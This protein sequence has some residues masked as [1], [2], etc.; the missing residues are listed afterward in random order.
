M[1]VTLLPSPGWNSGRGS[2]ADQTAPGNGPPSEF[3]EPIVKK[4]SYAK[5]GSSSSRATSSPEG[6]QDAFAGWL[7]HDPDVLFKLSGNKALPDMEYM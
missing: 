4:L 1:T 3:S 2:P 7:Y 5:N 6:F